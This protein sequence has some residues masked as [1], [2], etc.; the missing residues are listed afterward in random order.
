M[1]LAT[2]DA[3]PPPFASS[4]RTGR[5]RTSGAAPAI[6]TRV[7][8]VRS[9]DAGNVRAVTVGVDAPVVGGLDVVLA[10][11]T[12]IRAR[13]WWSA[14]TPESMT[15]T[16]DAAAP[17]H[18]PGLLERRPIERPLLLAQRVVLAPATEGGDRL[19]ALDAQD[20][21]GRQT[22]RGVVDELARGVSG[23]H[24]EVTIGVLRHHPGGQPG[25][26]RRGRR[27]VIGGSRGREPQNARAVTI[28]AKAPRAL[29]V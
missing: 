11:A 7:V 1:P 26:G 28:T 23:D 14:W 25:D 5:M 29:R 15:A 22:G 24:L 17:G 16:D 2:F 10:R 4:T 19:V 6:P 8:D 21:R 12:P 20:L 27:R 9:D 3:T 13:S 18:A